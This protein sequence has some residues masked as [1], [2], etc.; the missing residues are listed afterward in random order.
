M[1]F[2]N[3]GI[4]TRLILELLSL[5]LKWKK[6]FFI[7]DVEMKK[8]RLRN[9]DD[10]EEYNLTDTTGTLIDKLKDITEELMDNNIPWLANNI[11][12]W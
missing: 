7:W 8:R 4:R 5:W 9:R 10:K 3:I 2:W 12:A 1:I 6:L 11:V